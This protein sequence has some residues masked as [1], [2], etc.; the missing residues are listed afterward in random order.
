MSELSVKTHTC[1][2]YVRFV[3][4]NTEACVKNNFR[5]AVTSLSTCILSES[6]TDS[7]LLTMHVFY[8]VFVN[9]QMQI[10]MLK[11]ARIL[12]PEQSYC[13]L[14]TASYELS[15]IINSCDLVLLS[16]MW[17]KKRRNLTN[18]KIRNYTEPYVYNVLDT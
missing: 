10:F 4:I 16:I 9:V 8:L 13:C 3:C 2:C 15:I 18:S 5:A 12:M 6:S 11:A 1:F 7:I 14:P 17:R